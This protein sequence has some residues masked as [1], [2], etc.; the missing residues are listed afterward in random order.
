MFI[1]IQK[2][3]KNFFQP[4]AVFVFKVKTH[5]KDTLYASELN[6][7]H[8][9]GVA[10]SINTLLQY[11]SAA[12]CIGC[13]YFKRAADWC[14][15]ANQFNH[16]SLHHSYIYIYSMS[17]TLKCWA[18]ALCEMLFTAP[19]GNRETKGKNLALLTPLTLSLSLG[20]KMRAG[21]IAEEP[22]PLCLLKFLLMRQIKPAAPAN[23]W[24]TSYEQREDSHIHRTWLVTLRHSR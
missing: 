13:N 2:K 6:L 3:K 4:V 19:K 20:V 5:F 7:L 12:K 18:S 10:H 16:I 21:L 9:F 1:N 17:N 22:T 15:T 24:Q 23:D 8:S 11:G 14:M